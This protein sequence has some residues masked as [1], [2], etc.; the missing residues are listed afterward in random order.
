MLNDIRYGLRQLWKHPGFTLVATLTLALA[1]GG[2]TVLFTLIKGAYLEALPYP[3][4]HQIVTLSGQFAKAGEMPFSGPEFAALKER[5]GSLENMS[6]L[7]GAS[8]NL[9]G[10]GDAVRFRGLLATASLFRMLKTQPLLGRVFLE[11]EEERG[12]ERVAV[13][14]YQLWQRALGGQANIVGRQLRLNDVDYTVIGVMPPRFRYGDNDI[15]VPLGLDLARQDRNE[16]NIY[17]HARL[18]PNKSLKAVNAELANI[19]RQVRSNLGETSR[20][21]AG[22]NV[23]ATL[24]IDDVV[25]DVKSALGILL[26]AVGCV[27]LIA[28]A[29]ISNLQLARN[30]MREKEMAVRL[31]LGARRSDLVRQLLTESGLLAF[32]GGALGIFLAAWSL[33]PL[34]RL[35][36]YSYI[37]IEANVKIDSAVLVAAVGVTIVTALVVGLMPALKASRPALSNSIKDSRGAIGSALKHRRAQSLL[38]ISQIAL[39]FVMLIGCVLMLKSFARLQRIDPGFDPGRLVKMET[40]LPAARYSAATEVQRFY[41]ELLAQIRSIPGVQ[42]AGAVTILPF[43][44]FP[45]RAQFSIEGIPSEDAVPLAEQRQIMPGYL[46]T[47]GNTVV[48]GRDLIER[49]NSTS[50][51]V[52]LVNQTFVLKYFPETDPIGHR[53]RLEQSGSENPWLTIVGVTKDMRQLRMTDPVLPEIYRA[54]AQAPDA[55]RRMA[56]VLRSSMG[57]TSLVDGVRNALRAQDPAVPIFGAEPVNQLIERSFG[58][59]KLAVFLLELFGALALVL[60]VIGIYGVTAYFVAHRTSE[61]GI[62]IALGA[63]RHHVLKLILG[64]GIAMVM[65]GVTLGLAGAFGATRFLRSMLFEVSATDFPAYLLV[66]ASLAAAAIFACYIPARAAMKLNPSDA[67]RSE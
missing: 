31:A 57:L 5:T 17:V 9:S 15:W 3:Q 64:Q 54:H 50:M 19:A 12:R 48:R 36:P 44:S 45:A 62:R 52:A 42:S 56:F 46:E 25:R 61:I 53:V 34:L 47:L 37:P 39:T 38:V 41:G 49:D 18:A 14:S 33:E 30:V 24:L 11:E 26:G 20:D 60:T 32:F 35:I 21:R 28:C 27:L 7:I 2:T 59:Q 65:T 16:R 40:V 23:V 8:F 4:A 1:I 66:T 58:G 29:N 51:P 67:L 63:Q 10:E 43:A 6:A 13:I 55:S 22:W